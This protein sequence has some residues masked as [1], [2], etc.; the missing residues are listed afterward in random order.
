VAALPFT[1]EYFLFTF[2]APYAAFWHGSQA[3]EATQL[4]LSPA[5]CIVLASA[6][7][8]I[9]LYPS[10][11]QWLYK[12]HLW[13]RP[14]RLLSDVR[15]IE[16]RA[17]GARNPAALQLICGF[18]VAKNLCQG[19]VLWGMTPFAVTVP[20]LAQGSEVIG[21]ALYVVYPVVLYAGLLLDSRWWLGIGST[22]QLKRREDAGGLMSSSVIEELEAAREASRSFTGSFTTPLLNDLPSPMLGGRSG[23]VVAVWRD[24]EE[25]VDAMELGGRRSVRSGGGLSALRA[26][27]PES[28]GSGGSESSSRGDSGTIRSPGGSIID[29]VPRLKIG[30]VSLGSEIARGSYAKVLRGTYCGKPCAFKEFHCA[31]LSSSTVPELIKREVLAAWRLQHET[32][33]EFFGFFVDP[34]KVYLGFEYCQKG[35]LFDTLHKPRQGRRSPVPIPWESRVRMAWDACRAIEHLHSQDY[36][37]RDIKSLNFLVGTALDG[38]DVVKLADFGESKESQDHMTARQA[39]TLHWMAIYYVI[40]M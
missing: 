35:S 15:K 7:I 18:G 3:G 16:S 32:V 36:C 14:P 33:V 13:L 17:P 5:P 1:L 11:S 20:W 4:T 10:L 21:L 8:A 25:D 9:V 37:H 38:L 24:E 23:E 40:T 28:G 31:H 34:P 26:G 29:Q 6:Y 19:V 30:C 27:S 12:L 2:S 39:G 22:G